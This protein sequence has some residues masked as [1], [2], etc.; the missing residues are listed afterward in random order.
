MVTAGAKVLTLCLSLLSVSAVDYVTGGDNWE[1]TCITG[2]SQSPI[3]IDN[4]D[5]I[6]DSDKYAAHVNLLD[7][8]NINENDL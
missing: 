2:A 4:T 7:Y 5:D 8:S 3:N 6:E 1:G